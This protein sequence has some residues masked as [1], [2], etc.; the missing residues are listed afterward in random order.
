MELCIES[1]VLLSVSF[2]TSISIDN[3]IK[4]TKVHADKTKGRSRGVAN[5]AVTIWL[6]ET[7]FF[8]QAKSPAL[9]LPK[10]S[11]ALKL[12]GGGAETLKGAGPG[13]VLLA[14]T[15]A[16]AHRLPQLFLPPRAT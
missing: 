2:I 3:F 15:L 13:A 16:I 4:K 1:A 5:H 11:V 10:I 12:L 9:Q 6:S 8:S 7:S 14:V